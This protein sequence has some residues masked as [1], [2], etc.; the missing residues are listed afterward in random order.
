MRAIYNHMLDDYTPEPSTEESGYEA[1]NVV[2]ALLY[3]KWRTET[4][5][6]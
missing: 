1:V 4:D 2:D 3:K 6:R 5:R